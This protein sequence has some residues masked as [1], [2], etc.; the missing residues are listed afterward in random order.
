M[1]M[2]TFGVEQWMNE[3]ETTAT[4]NLGETC[5]SPLSLH[6][7]LNLT[8]TNE[9]EFTQKML[10]TRLTYGDI[11]GA[12]E[13][14]AGI[15]QL[16]Q[17]LKPANI[18]TTHGAIGANSLV[19]TTL[20]EPGDEV[21]VVTPTY[22]QLQSI[23][24]AIGATVRLL[25]L[26]PENDYLPDIDQLKALVNDK[27]KL[28]ILNNPDNP[29]GSLMPQEHLQR[30][31]DVAK[32]VD[33]Y[34]LCDE[35]YRHLTQTDNYS[36]SI[37]DLYA[38]GIS[39]SSMSKVFSLAGLRLGWVATHDEA[40]MQTILS[41]RDYNTISCGV[42][43]E[44]V[45][46]V[47]LDHKDALLKRNRGIVRKN[48]AILSDWVDSQ[49]HIS[50]VKPQAGTTALLH[51][52]F[53]LPSEQFCDQLFKQTGVLLVPGAEFDVEHALR[54]GYA[55]ESQE[56]QNGLDQLSEFMKTLG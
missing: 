5:V 49:P 26:K 29:S 52:D 51:Y 27:T 34:I 45:A 11:V 39:T 14:R 33:A 2:K 9:T 21:V 6:A 44:M 20:V 16:Y 28:I 10:N 48:L 54:I 19:L 25:A 30:I 55:F 40:F 37:I 42:L 23:P 53:D 31:I 8:Q 56:L 41:H 46:E 1:K 35:V 3:Y 47:A 32:S 50:W 7:L 13:L 4:Y 43:D 24:E 22:Q 18:V 15:T 17:N 36:P 12:P 38:K